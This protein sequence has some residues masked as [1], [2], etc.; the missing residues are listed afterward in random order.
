[1]RIHW[2]Y[3]INI[4]TVLTLD[5]NFSSDSEPVTVKPIPDVIDN[6]K[7]TNLAVF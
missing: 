7:S 1:M 2:K 5:K 6:D 4:Q 3:I